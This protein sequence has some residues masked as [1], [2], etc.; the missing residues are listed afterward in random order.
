MMALGAC[1][2]QLSYK[3]NYCCLEQ[4]PEVIIWIILLWILGACSR[5]II[6]D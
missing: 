4:A 3:H 1:S 2:K 5:T 6:T